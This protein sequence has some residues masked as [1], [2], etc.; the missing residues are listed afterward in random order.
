MKQAA[1][2][3]LVAATLLCCGSALAVVSTAPQLAGVMFEG[4]S[5]YSPEALLPLYRE[6]LGR[7]L[8][9]ALQQRIC[10][11]LVAQYQSDGYLRPVVELASRHSEAGVL[12]FNVREPAVRQVSVAGQEFVSDTQFWQQLADLQHEAP[13]SKQTFRDWLARVNEADDMLVTGTIAPIGGAAADYAAQLQVAARPLTGMIHVDNQAPKS[14][15]YEMV[16]GVASYR[17]ADVHAGQLTAAVAA[18]VNVDRLE[19]ASIAGTHGIDDAGRA[20]EWSAS[21]SKSELPSGIHGQPNDYDRSRFTTGFRTPLYHGAVATLDVWTTLQV[22]DV[23]ATDAS[24]AT[25]SDDRI[26]SVEVGA[27]T[28]I[29]NTTGRRHDV[30][31]SVAQ[32]LD[33]L[34]ARATVQPGVAQPDLDYQRY[35]LSYRVTQQIG[36]RWNASLGMQAQWSSDNVP[37]SERFIIGGRQLGGA[38]DPASVTGDRGVG[39]RAEFARIGSL[40]RLNLPMQTYAYTDYGLAR[41]NSDAV[42]SDSASSAGGGVRMSY[43]SLSGFLEV[44][45]P[46]EQPDSNPLARQ[47]TRVFFSLTKTFM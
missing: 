39:A 42:P 27:S 23:D 37:E 3:A 10:A 15:G 31:L 28:S 41:S 32:G 7:P 36:D 16:Q 17:F 47:G 14:L 8:D 6:D 25:I 46:I 30:V 33:S 1:G 24:G 11:G 12:V 45:T 13:L 2:I 21:G 26:R 38:F 20:F 35:V 4:A 29:V 18:A 44:A 34:G 40:P 43:G 9:E 22:Y 5:R 19:F